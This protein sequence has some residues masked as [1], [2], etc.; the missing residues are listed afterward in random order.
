G[1]AGRVQL[2]Q[3]EPDAARGREASAQRVRHPA[4]QRLEQAVRLAGAD[5]DDDLA[6]VAKVDRV[7]KPVALLGGPGLELELDVDHELAG[8]AP[9]GGAGAVAPLELQAVERDGQH[10]AARLSRRWTRLRLTLA[11][12]PRRRGAACA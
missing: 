5:V 6:D 10:G 3:L 9:L 12:P 8:A 7:G 1:A 2:A 4:R 11:P